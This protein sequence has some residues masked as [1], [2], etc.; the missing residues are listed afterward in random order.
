MKVGIQSKIKRL[1][2]TGAF[3]ITLGTFATKFVAFFGSVFVVRILTKEQYG[4]LGYV[5]NIG[6]YALIFAGFGLCYSIL[7][8]V[9]IAPENKRRSYYDYC[10]KNSLIRDLVISLIIIVANFFIRYPDNFTDSKFW[11]PVIAILIPLQ[12]VVNCEL[13]SLRSLFKNKAYAYLSFAV[14]TALIVGR[15]V[16]GKVANVRGVIW[17]GLFI[18]AFFAIVL[19]ANT[20]RLYGNS[21]QENLTKSEKS[22]CNMYGLQMMVTN[23]LWALFMLN[24]TFLLGTL[25]N[26]P[27]VLA[28]YKVAYV[29]PGNI[30]IF[31]TAIGIYISPYF[32][33]HEKDFDWVKR[34]YKKAFIAT[35][36]IVGAVTVILIFISAPLIDIVYGDNYKNVVGLMRLLL[37]AAFI[38]SG[39]RY[40][41]ANLLSAMGH[42]KYNL[43][44]SAIGVV[45]Q[46]GLDVL[47]I[48][49]MRAVGVALSSC[50]VNLFMAIALYIVF[51]KI[52]YKRHEDS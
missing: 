9:I 11:V 32:T 29:F 5:E 27:S 46:I 21:K 49:Y 13:Y 17:S 33:K 41:S 35:A 20:N 43:I 37:I 25:C 31:S 16:G 34:N 42:A 8:F 30:S 10:L 45:A 7:R 4:L 47:L 18:N 38:N 26:D 48:P 51:L 15:V 2:D 3:H 1:L 22:E 40:T 19:L 14:S 12:D 24:D 44:I 28:D 6:S 52:Y 36:S 50:I 23:G 39:L